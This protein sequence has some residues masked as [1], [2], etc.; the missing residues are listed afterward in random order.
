[1][2]RGEG[3]QPISSAPQER[4]FDEFYDHQLQVDP[5]TLDEY[6]AGISDVTARAVTIDALEAAIRLPDFSLWNQLG[7]AGL[8]TLIH[9]EKRAFEVIGKIDTTDIEQELFTSRS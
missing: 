8:K 5:E 3:L 2:K 6:H 9:V 7:R 1:M 4:N